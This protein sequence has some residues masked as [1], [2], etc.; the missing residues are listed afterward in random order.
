MLPRGPNV[1][2]HQ[3]AAR[4][5][6]SHS[7]ADGFLPAS[8]SANVVHGQAGDN[9]IKTVVFEGERRDVPGVQFDAIGHSFG[10][11]VAPRS[12]Q[13][14]AGLIEISPQVHTH[15]P[16]YGQTL[17]GHEEHGAPATSQV[18][19][20]LITPQ[21]QLVNQAGPNHEFAP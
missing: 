5:Q 12:F 2:D 7:F 1:G 21:V 15:R 10:G 8:A 19:N 16:A 6:H 13:R 3:P 4:T 11:C 18:Q 14:V 9:Q 20:P 17:R